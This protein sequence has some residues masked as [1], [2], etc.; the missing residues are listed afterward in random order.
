MDIVGDVI[1]R[2]LGAQ[3]EVVAD[4]LL[5]KALS[6][7]TTDH[8]VRKLQILD[9]GLKLSL[10]LLCDLATEDHGNLVGLAD[11]TISVEQSLAELIQCGS[12]ME[13]QVVT[14]FYLGKEEPV[15]TARF[16]ALAFFKE[17]SQTG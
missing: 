9:D 2:F 7:V 1:G 16:F 4:V 5:E 14:I 11:G 15:L 6:I 3:A 10:V 8:W 12:P 13:D 17:W